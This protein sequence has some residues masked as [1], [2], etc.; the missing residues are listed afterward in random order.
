[1]LP[2]VCR[3]IIE[4]EH[5][6]PVFCQTI[7]RFRILGIIGFNCIFLGICHIDIVNSLF[8]FR[9]NVLWKLIQNI[10]CLMNPTPLIPAIRKDFSNSRPET[11]RSVANEQFR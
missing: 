2:M 4:S 8:C 3:K 7:S 1:M 6:I 11:E 5:R 9:L 10:S